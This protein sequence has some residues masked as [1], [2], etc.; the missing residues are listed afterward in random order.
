[1]THFGFV[2]PGTGRLRGHHETGPALFIQVAV[3]IAD[4]DVVAIRHLAF[5]V[6]AR[7]AKGQT[8]VVFDFFGIDLVHIK[9]W[10]SHDKVCLAQQ[11]MRVFIVGDGFLDVAFETMHCQVHLSQTDGGGVLF[12]TK[13][14]ELLSGV[15]MSPFDDPSALHKHAART[16]GRVKHPAVCWFDDVGNQRH[17]RHRS[18]ELAAVVGLLVGELGQEIFVDAAKD[19]SGNP[20]QFLGIKGA[21]QLA[22]HLVIEFLIFALGKHASQ[23]LVVGFNRLHGFDN[24]LGAVGAVRQSHEGVELGLGLQEDGAFLREILLGQRSGLAAPGGQA[25]FDG[26]LDAQ[27]PAVGMAQEDQAHDRQKIF[28]ARVV[29]VRPQCVCRAPET[30]FNSFNVFQLGH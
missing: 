10:I 30:L 17:Q 19:I 22:K 14:S 5:F 2:A 23:V 11:L 3:E 26:V 8:W 28:V 4:P 6:D 29:G 21:Q 24:R 20:L 13:E 7:Q 18:E 1:M 16:A 27:I 12:Q 9:G 25:R 15:L